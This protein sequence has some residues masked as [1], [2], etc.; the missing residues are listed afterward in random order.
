[1]TYLNFLAARKAKRLHITHRGEAERSLARTVLSRGESDCGV[2][3]GAWFLKA[4][5]RADPVAQH[6][7]GQSLLK[8]AEQALHT[9]PRDLSGEERAYR[10]K[11][12]SE[13]ALEG[14]TWLDAAAQ[15]GNQ[16]A[17]QDLNK[18]FTQDEII[19]FPDS[20]SA[21]QYYLRMGSFQENVRGLIKSR[22]LAGLDP[23]L[24]H[25]MLEVQSHS[26]MKKRQKVTEAIYNC[27]P[28]IKDLAKIVTD[29][30]EHR[31]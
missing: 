26:D 5:Y 25:F 16:E 10:F 29:Y 6:V 9:L 3:A 24:E 17:V 12:I 8:K 28:L 14:L 21:V 23:K 30:A 20:L 31:R 18:L 13:C 15:N 11:G 4:C 22:E 27:T 7:Y 2:V 1:M 19:L